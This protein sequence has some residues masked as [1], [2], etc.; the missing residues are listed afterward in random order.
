MFEGVIPPTAQLPNVGKKTFDTFTGWN[1]DYNEMDEID[2]VTNTESS[3]DDYKE[4]E[5]KK[6]SV[7]QSNVTKKLENYGIIVKFNDKGKVVY[8]GELWKGMS[9]EIKSSIK[10][11]AD[12]L[13]LLEEGGSVNL[14]RSDE[15]P[16][17]KIKKVVV[18]SKRQSSKS[19]L[20]L[21]D[22]LPHIS[23][24]DSNDPKDLS[25]GK[26]LTYKYNKV[27][28]EVVKKWE[29]RTIPQSNIRKVL[30][31]KGGKDEVITSLD[32]VKAGVSTRKVVSKTWMDKIMDRLNIENPKSLVGTVIKQIDE[33]TGESVYTQITSVNKFTEKYQEKTWDLE[34]WSR[35][36]T[37]RLLKKYKDKEG[38]PSGWAIEFKLVSPNRNYV[39]VEKVISGFQDGVDREV[40]LDAAK[41]LGLKTSGTA[42]KGFKTQEGYKPELAKKY[43]IFEADGR[44]DKLIG[45]LK[46]NWIKF[47]NTTWY[48]TYYPR[49]IYNILNSDAT[50][51]FAKEVKSPG[52]QATIDMLD[53]LPIK[54]PYIV[55]PTAKQLKEFLDKHKPQTINVA[56]NRA[57]KLGTTNAE[58]IKK[59]NEFK[60][61]LK[62]AISEH[63]S[64]YVNEDVVYNEE[65]TY[66]DQ[67]D[68]S[69]EETYEETNAEDNEE[70]YDDDEANEPTTTKEETKESG[71]TDN[72][73]LFSKILSEGKE[74]QI[75]DIF[76]IFDEF[77]STEKEIRKTIKEKEDESKKCNK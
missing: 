37:N 42:P 67:Y 54:K 65:E 1:P 51:I 23:Q 7:K 17:K 56:G 10:S 11:H 19:K 73:E 76:S 39:G 52:T 29:E 12:L 47:S 68:D 44:F 18:S 58:I 2:E 46:E 25:R 69:Y 57:T 8:S 74:E 62:S 30:S 61:I 59:I 22:E 64:E 13:R 4:I 75:N 35:D 72:I 5:S 9:K 66:T 33:F 70:E 55:N 45:T 50:V 36:I 32:M 71:L 6:S 43:N 3:Q 38:E 28:N 41:E 34:G 15:E 60:K 24:S 63:N 27:K 53:A 26:Y 49:N 31:I 48:D 21:A 14:K 40:G 77:G 20:D 16:A